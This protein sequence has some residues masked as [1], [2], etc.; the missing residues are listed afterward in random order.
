MNWANYILQ[1]PMTL[2]ERRAE[3]SAQFRKEK[4][5]E[6]KRKYKERKKCMNT[7]QQ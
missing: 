5:K 6:Y 2:D 3:T 7:K 4:L 1:R